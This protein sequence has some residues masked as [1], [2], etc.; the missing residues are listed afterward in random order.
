MPR[1]HIK[2]SQSGHQRS[3]IDLFKSAFDRH[4]IEYDFKT[5]RGGDWA[6]V[7]G[8]RSGSDY[9]KAGCN[10]IVAERGYIGDRFKYTSIGINGLNGRA[11]FVEAPDPDNRFEP[12]KHLLKPWNPYGDYV[13]ICGQ[14][15]GD[16]ALGGV[17]L[18]PW[19]RRKA[20]EY[21]SKGYRVKFRPHPLGAVR[22]AIQHLGG[23]ETDSSTL[24]ESLSGAG[25]VITY[26]SNTGVDALL[27]GKIATCENEGALIHCWDG[28]E[29]DRIRL[30]KEVSCYQWLDEEIASGQAIENLAEIIKNG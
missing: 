11:T 19:Y 23:C 18:N 10:V 28:S 8:W 9:R 1:V 17:D 25:L 2:L 15:P 20:D 4:G 30:L 22:G 6:L 26:N 7:W 12:H 24:E 5:P 21:L 16:A 27:S 3:K 14:V 13:L 29:S